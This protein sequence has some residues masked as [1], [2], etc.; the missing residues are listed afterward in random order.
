MP[1]FRSK[2]DGSTE[3]VFV[4]SSSLPVT[5]RLTMLRFFPHAY[6]IKRSLDAVIAGAD[7]LVSY[8]LVA[9]VRGRVMTV[10]SIWRDEAS[11]RQ[12]VVSDVHRKAMT[13]LQSSVEGGTFHTEVLSQKQSV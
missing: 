5:S 3:G 11:F 8:E 6:R 1:T 13:A 9:D 2:D 12:W 7:G 10:A 4:F